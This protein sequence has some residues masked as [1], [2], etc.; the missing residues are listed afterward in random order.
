MRE[1]EPNRS[2]T[3]AT[4]INADSI[5]I[6]NLKKREVFP[7]TVAPFQDHGR[8][9]FIGSAVNSNPVFIEAARALNPDESRK[10]NEHLASEVERIL[11]GNETRRV[12]TLTSAGK[13]EI[14]ILSIG[15]SFDPKGL[16]VYYTRSEFE[17]APAIYQL[18]R[19]KY[20]DARKVERVFEDVGYRA[21]KNWEKRRVH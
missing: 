7:M 21:A 9:C 12:A 8:P 6:P 4:R 5:L 10:A 16:R 20:K 17:G 11:D 18:A 13:P 15:E 1:Q 2:K 19:A 3:S 14:Y